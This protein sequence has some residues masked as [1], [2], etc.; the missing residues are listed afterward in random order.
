[1]VFS[2]FL[3]DNDRSEYCEQS[4]SYLLYFKEE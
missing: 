4:V 2:V 3:G 1:M